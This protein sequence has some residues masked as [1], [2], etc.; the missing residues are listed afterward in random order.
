MLP[1]T[2]LA[3]LLH[4][5]VEIPASLSFLLAPHAQLPGASAEARL[6][7][8]NLGGLLAATNLIVL[9]ILL[10]NPAEAVSA[11][12]AAAA[13]TYRLTAWLCLCLGTYHVWPIHRAWVRMKWSLSSSHKKEEKKVLGGPAVHFMVH[14]LCLTALLGAGL[15]GVL[16]G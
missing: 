11:T 16:D 7:L 5:L 10:S 3:L 12:A 1:P 14:V 15:V 6:I 8:R 2:K 4:L 13:E 9:V